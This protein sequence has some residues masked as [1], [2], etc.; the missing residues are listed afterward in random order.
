[1]RCAGERNVRCSVRHSVTLLGLGSRPEN[2][3]QALHRLVPWL[4]HAQP[5]HARRADLCGADPAG[6]R[7]S[8]LVE[9]GEEEDGLGTHPDLV[10]LGVVQSSGHELGATFRRHALGLVLLEP[11][12]G[13]LDTGLGSEGV[14]CD[15]AL[16][17]ARANQRDVHSAVGHLV[18]QRAVVSL[19]GVLGRR[20]GRRAGGPHLASH[21]GGDHDVPAS[22]VQHGWEEGLGH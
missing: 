4:S 19:D 13:G 18:P 11:S 21:G 15:L 9:N 2:H 10:Q 5:L 12:V 6:K 7:G 8:D 17:G 14:L 16:N 1:M 22:A 20:V 3:S